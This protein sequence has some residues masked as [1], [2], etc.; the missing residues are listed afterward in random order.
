MAARL[1]KTCAM[2]ARHVKARE[3]G[4]REQNRRNRR[5]SIVDVATRYF[6][7]HG[8][9]ATS[10]SAIAD[11]IGGSKAT[12]WSHFSSKEEL[13]AAVVDRQ[14]A[15]L[16]QAISADV[17][18]QCYSLDGLRH[19]CRTFLRALL[20]PETLALYRII[21]GDG[22]RFAELNTIFFVRGPAKAM[23]QLTRFFATAI[24]REE[25]ERLAMVINTALW[26]WRSYVLTR[27][28]SIE[29]GEVEQFVVDLLAHVRLPDE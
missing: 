27:A 19:Y 29:A 11:E 20:T 25:A 22:A 12:L 24:A 2:G 5:V 9:A 21:L 6:L 10:M 3:P 18:A 14:V 16:E 17:G 7:D 15:L 28:T 13:F 23:D 8:Y 4:K 1:P 26:G